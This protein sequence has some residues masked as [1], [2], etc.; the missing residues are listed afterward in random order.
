MVSHAVVL[1]TRLALESGN[2]LSPRAVKSVRKT[3]EDLA[4][5][6]VREVAVV[7]GRQADTLRD[8]LALHELPELNVRVLANLSWKNLSGSALLVARSWIEGAHKC[9]VVR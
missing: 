1:A 4:A 6:G 8:L 9:L 5:I 2:Q 7:D 3:L